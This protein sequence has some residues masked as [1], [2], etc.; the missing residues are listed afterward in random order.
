MLIGGGLADEPPV[1]TIYV[2][3]NGWH[4]SL[5]VARND[6]PANLP[7]ET[8][9]FPE[10]P[11]LEFGWGDRDFYTTPRPTAAMALSATFGFGPSV[12]YVAG[13][14]RPPHEFFLGVETVGIDVPE[15]VLERLLAAV[16]RGFER[17]GQP[18]AEMLP[19]R[20]N[21]YG[22]FYPGTGAF[23]LFNTCNT[24][25]VKS[26]ADAGV[27]VS[28]TGVVTAGQLM[29]RL[30]DMPEATVLMR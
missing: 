17:G 23:T 22:R 15:A 28:S 11:Y 19:V 5:V 25:V 13:L 16:D 8:A 7:P 29:D 26:L 12:M 3:S 14:D 18:R 20:T 9:D 24:W 2:F 4:S 1:R 10:A 30:K 27:A 21:D 6:L